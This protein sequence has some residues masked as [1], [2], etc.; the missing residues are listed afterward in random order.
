MNVNQKIASIFMYVLHSMLHIIVMIIIM[1]MNLYVILIIVVG[2]TLGN[3]FKGSDDCPKQ[4]Q[5]KPCCHSSSNN[6]IQ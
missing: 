2:A 5:P 4:L 6:N 3:F 1:A